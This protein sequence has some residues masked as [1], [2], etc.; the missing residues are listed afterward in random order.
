ML[1][2][3]RNEAGASM[4]ALDLREWLH[5]CL[6]EGGKGAVSPRFMNWGSEGQPAA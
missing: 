3:A 5:L 2:Q 6:Q 4:E 1:L